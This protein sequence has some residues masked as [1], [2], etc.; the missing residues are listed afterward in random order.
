MRLLSEA[1]TTCGR[2]GGLAGSLTS[3]FASKAVRSRVEQAKG[4]DFCLR[5]RD[6]GSAARATAFTEIVFDVPDLI[7]R[8]AEL[9]G[10][11]LLA[12]ERTNRLREG[13]N[14]PACASTAG[15]IR[16]QRVVLSAG[17]G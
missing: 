12:G 3:F 14:W 10:D 1:C 2:P 5:A 7:R 11:S 8:L 17:A 9:A 13:R 16:A 15:R 6:K 4:E